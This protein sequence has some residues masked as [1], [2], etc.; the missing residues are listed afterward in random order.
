MEYHYGIYITKKFWSFYDAMYSKNGNFYYIIALA[1]DT[2][3]NRLSFFIKFLDPNEDSTEEFQT[4]EFGTPVFF[5]SEQ[6]TIIDIYRFDKSP[7]FPIRLPNNDLLTSFRSIRCS[8]ENRDI[9]INNKES[10]L[11]SSVYKYHL[12]EHI[13]NLISQTSTDRIESLIQEEREI[14][15][16][17]NIDDIINELHIYHLSSSR[18]TTESC[19]EYRVSI[20]RNFRYGSKY[21]DVKFDDYLNNILKIGCEVID[22][23]EIWLSADSHIQYIIGQNP[24]NEDKIKEEIR[25]KYSRKEHLN[26]RFQKRLHSIKLSI[27]RFA[28]HPAEFL[29]ITPANICK[30]LPNL[31]SNNPDYILHQI[32]DCNKS[33]FDKDKDVIYSN[34]K[35]I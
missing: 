25:E 35:V 14:V 11:M 9:E 34:L 28:H 24:I 1:S 6:E 5:T 19:E 17:Y 30:H 20:C 29:N 27:S 33:L 18:P 2:T 8:S 4:I 3:K 26:Y 13:T 10:D 23:G 16:S 22:E 7:S 15:E 31:C 32:K 12:Y 21:Y